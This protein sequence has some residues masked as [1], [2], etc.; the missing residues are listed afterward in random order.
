MPSASSVDLER[1]EDFAAALRP[2]LS[3]ALRLDPL[4]RALY[5]TDASLYRIEPLG[6][7]VPRTPDDIQAALEASALFS[8][9]LLPRGSGTSLAGSA[10]G[11]ALVVDTSRHLDSI[12]AIDPEERTATVEPGVVL[13]DLNRAAAMHGLIFGPDPASSNR[14]TL[15]GMVGTNATGARSIRYGSVVDHVIS[16]RALLAGGH[17][18]SLAPVDSDGWDARARSIGAEADVYRRMDSV[19]RLHERAIREDTPRHWRRAGGYRLER[20]MDAEEVD[21]GPGRR[22]DG[23]RN[24]AHLL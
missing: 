5:A 18:I 15:G 2:R 3:G 23:T 8:V 7:L 12:V 1:L 21:L 14:A 6:V 13:D 22:W 11:A 20:L 10:V 9:P 4:H 19:L 16:A 24:L 17:P